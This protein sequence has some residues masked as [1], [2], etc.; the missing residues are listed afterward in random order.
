VGGAHD[1]EVA[2]VEGRDHGPVEAFSDGDEAGID[3]VESEI[4]VDVGELDAADPVIRDEFDSFELASGDE[5]EEPLVG[6]VPRQSRIN[7][8]DSAITGVGDAQA[9]P[10]SKS[11]ISRWR[12]ER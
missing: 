2:V 3:E 4:V 1:G 6:P 10:V 7:Q 9:C 11:M 5:A 12:V 8:A